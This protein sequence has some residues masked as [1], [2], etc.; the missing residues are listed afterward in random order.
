MEKDDQKKA[1][2]LQQRINRRMLLVLGCLWLAGSAFSLAGVWHE[3]GKQLDG[4]LTDTAERFL[5]L[6]EIALGDVNG[7][8]LHA[9]GALHEEHLVYQVFD[10]KGRM[11]LRSNT[12]PDSPLDA[13]LQDGVRDIDGWHVLTLTRQDGHRRVEVADTMRHR[14][15]VLWGALGWLAGALLLLLPAASIALTL[16]LRNGFRTLDPVRAELSSRSAEDL[17]P[18]A[19]ADAPVE[20]QPWLSSVNSLLARL[21]SLV[22]A[23]RRFSSHTAHELRTPLA[24]ARARAQRLA[25]S[26]SDANSR[27]DAHALVRQLDRL[28]RVATRLLQMARIESGATLQRKPVDL[29]LLARMIVAEFSDPTLKERVRLEV[30]GT[31]VTVL[32]DIDAIGIALRNLIDNA[33]KHGGQSSWITV[34]VEGTAVSVVDDGPGVPPEVLHKLVRPFERGMSAASGSGLGLSITNAI[35]C[36]AG[37]TMELQSPIF[38]GRGFA[39]VLRFERQPVFDFGLLNFQ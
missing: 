34:L 11:R 19:C 16:I 3:T 18:I 15:E 20:L 14:R 31:P 8:R 1:W 10:A 21:R 33:L 37:G 35:V 9:E 12:A 28:A 29:A 7:A 24:A 30:S 23:E 4:S 32:G 13:R 17:Q 22:A 5:A 25:E 2:S 39:A 36:Q 27:Q 38:G 26:T 6:P